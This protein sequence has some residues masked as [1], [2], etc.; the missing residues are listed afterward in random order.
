MTWK[1]RMYHN[2]EISII[3]CVQQMSPYPQNIFNNTEAIQQM[4][5]KHFYKHAKS[6][7]WRV[8]TKKSN[9]FRNE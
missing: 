2:F 9:V 5:Y 8:Q 6:D 3:L 7:F 4:G 1:N